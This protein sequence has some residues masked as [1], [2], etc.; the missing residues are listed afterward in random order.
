MKTT[1]YRQQSAI[2]FGFSPLLELSISYQI[3]QN[4]HWWGPQRQWAEEA[5]RALNGVELPMMDAV[6]PPNHYIA[7]FVTPAPS[8]VRTDLF[9]DLDDLRAT[10]LEQIRA[11]IYECI[12]VGGESAARRFFLKE[13]RRAIELLIAEL[14]LYWARALDPY[15]PRIQAT[16]ENDI[17]YRGRQLAV[18]GVGSLFRQLDEHVLYSEKDAVIHIKKKEHFLPPNYPVALDISEHGVQLVPAAFGQFYWQADENQSQTPMIIYRMR[19]AGLWYSTP[20][21]DPFSDLEVALGIGRARVLRALAT[22]ASVIE[23]AH[24]LGVTSGA[25]SQH[26]A[27]LGEAGLV[28][29]HRS[30]KRV[31]YRLTERGEGLLRLFS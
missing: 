15:W 12:T 25:V 24:R 19:G 11:D 21:Q 26:L 8:T 31:Y 6:I 20:K 22:P 30:G 18:E 9:A 3:L 29:P 17:L 13:P 16:L 1:L 27:R 5:L 4:P 28:H 7:D 10:P 2:R 14:Q 23:L